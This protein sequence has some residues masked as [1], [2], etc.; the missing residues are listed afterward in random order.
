MQEQAL[1]S[2]ILA[3]M[4]AELLIL[5]IPVLI[6]SVIVHEVAH[7]YAAFFQGDPTAYH[8]GRLTMNP[9][10]HLDPFGSVVLPLLTAWS[11]FFFG[12]AKPVPYNPHNLKNKKWG[13]AMVAFAGPLAN[14]IIALIFALIIRIMDTMYGLDPTSMVAQGLF[15][16]V[17]AN[18]FLAI[19]NLIP[20]PPLDGSKI[21]F[22][23]LPY[24]WI[25][26]R[27]FMEQYQLVFFAILLVI[28]FTTDIL[29][30]ITYVLSAL[31]IG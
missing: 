14:I 12:Y 3:I 7:G 21:L 29:Q 27:R 11:G 31:L 2:D 23:V 19:L 13:E 9:L 26:V 16:I 28:V 6:V 15:F 30:T 22:S 20:F 18:M 1:Y 24:K 8:Q 4:T 17:I 25:G 5:V 10:A